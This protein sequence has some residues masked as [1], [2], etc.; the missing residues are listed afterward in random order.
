MKVGVKGLN[1]KAMEE[2]LTD[3]I[4]LF[5]CLN[6]KLVFQL[7][8]SKKLSDRLIQGKTQSIIAE[9]MF[10]SKLKSEAGVTYVNKM[11]NMMQ[12]LETS[13]VEMDLF[14]NQKHR[15]SK[16]FKLK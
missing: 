2:K 7:E 11:T 1:E 12:D 9:K 5:R 14:R 13:R 16:L 15:V 6:N 8:Y 3:I 4:N 10:I